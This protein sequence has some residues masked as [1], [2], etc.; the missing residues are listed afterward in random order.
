MSPRE[1]GDDLYGDGTYAG[2]EAGPPGGS[3]AAWTVDIATLDGGVTLVDATPIGSL[4]T[5]WSLDGPGSVEAD[6]GEDSAALW[7]PGQRRYRVF[8]SGV[9]WAE[10][11]LSS[12]TESTQSYT[13]LSKPRGAPLR[14]SGLGL[15]GRLPM[16]IVHGDFSRSAVVATTI[17]WDLIQHAQAQTNGDYGFTL[18]TVTGVANART[19]HYCDGDNIADAINELAAKVPGG[20]DWEIDHN[21]DF[22]AWVGGRGTDMSGSIT[23]ERTDTMTWGVDYET[24]DLV[25]YATVLGEADEPCG[26]PLVSKSSTLK[27]AYGRLESVIELDTNDSGELDEAAEEELRSRG[28]ARCRV[29]ATWPENEAPW[30]FG[31]VWLG[32]TIS[33]VLPTH[34]GGTQDMR[35]IETAVSVEPP[36]FAWHEYEFETAI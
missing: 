29:H 30:T 32:D 2:E 11:W 28:A 15:A 35:M 25:T 34:F 13:D 20:F 4:R 1:Y 19:R 23:L 17:A 9:K 31:D 22:N 3:P 5:I 10:G 14:A 36:E 16:R 26:A 24:S 18:G 12:L 33:V 7:L 8:L 27:T 21:G 6:L